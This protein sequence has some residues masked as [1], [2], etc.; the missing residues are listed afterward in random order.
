MLATLAN[1]VIA[2]DADASLAAKAGGGKHPTDLKYAE[3]NS[4]LQLLT[5]KTQKALIEEYIAST[6]GYHNIKLD[7]VWSVRR[8][9][10]DISF[11]KDISNHKLLW[12]GTN[13]AVVA[14]ILK[15]GL[16][17]M[18]AVNGGRVGRGIYMA[19]MLEK[20]ASYVR[21]CEIGGK[22][23]GMLFLVEAALGKSHEILHDNGSFTAAPS[24]FQS[25]LATGSTAP[26][27][28]G[29]KLLTLDGTAIQVSCNS[30][31]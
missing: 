26:P 9:P 27:A 28:I 25:V 18:P 30:Q 14:A 20:S 8:H 21:P 29:D 12:H 4:D 6:K 17:I 24:G 5:D 19:N 16:R 10:E 11:A 15:T 23:I 22:R 1:I 3:L 7:T 13:V 31:L 2:Q